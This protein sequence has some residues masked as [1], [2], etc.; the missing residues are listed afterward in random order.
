M[1]RLTRFWRALI[2][3][4]TVALAV[5]GLLVGSAA[6][7]GA[8]APAVST[9]SSFQN[10]DAVVISPDG[11]TAYVADQ[12]AKVGNDYALFVVSTATNTITRTIT[13]PSFD[14]PM[15]VALSPSGSELYVLNISGTV[16]VV[17]TTTD[18]VTAV[19]GTANGEAIYPTPQG[20]VISP[21]GTT[22]YVAHY[23][24]GIVSVLNLTTNSVTRTITVSSPEALALTPSGKD[25]Y[26]SDGFDASSPGVEEIS[27]TTGSVVGSVTGLTPGDGYASLDVSPDGSTLYVVNN[28]GYVDNVPT[29]TNAVASTVSGFSGQPGDSVLSP[30]GSALYVGEG[31]D[32]AVVDTATGTIADE[33]PFGSAAIIGNLPAVSA[34]AV[35][36]SGGS[37]YVAG[38]Q[39]GLGEFGV[40][41]TATATLTGLTPTV[42]LNPVAVAFSPDGK[43]AYVVNGEWLKVP[44]SVT[45]IDTATGIA[46]AVIQLPEYSFPDGIAVSPDGQTIY[47]TDSGTSIPA[48]AGDTVSVIDAAT[49]AVTGSITVG[50]APAGAA[51]SP[52][53][54]T[55]YVANSDDNTVS[56]IDVATETAINT[57]NVGT[58][59][60]SVAVSPDGST[61]YVGTRQGISVIDTASDTVTASISQSEAI[62]FDVVLSPDGQT[63]YA[64]AGE[65]LVIS[66][67]TDT[68]SATNSSVCVANLAIALDGKTVYGS[69]A[70]EVSELSST[71]ALTATITDPS[72]GQLEGLAVS[73]SSGGIYLTD[74]INDSVHV[75]TPAPAGIAPAITSAA[76]ATF[77]VGTKGTFT[78]VTSGSPVPAITESGT[79]PKGVAFTAGANGTATL[80]GTPAAGT[81]KI[82]TLT[83]TAANGVGTVAT[84]HFK[85]TVDQP[86]KIT[87]AAKATFTYHR[88]ASFVIRTTG[89]PVVATITES[90]ALPKG[91][92]FRNN[93][94]GTATIAGTPQQKADK[95]YT[96]KIKASN[97]VSPAMTLTFKLTLKK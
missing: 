82:Y 69:C 7:E 79:L 60:G 15:A 35:S 18:S 73:P 83:I 46:T 30:N 70:S 9:I 37:V 4:L 68:V 24:L 90:G 41:S 53:G 5:S 56:V 96:L 2:G 59:P 40:I 63:L 67:K 76:A 54:T 93:K 13:D 44:A 65:L 78:V 85:L 64:G 25:L 14:E 88:K 87:S 58:D 66:T 89:Y 91:L 42:G 72:F 57:I 51:F 6:A 10:P 95:T 47:V 33:I 20:I 16:S 28:A 22:A 27:T 26:V 48:E 84:Q 71:G 38:T 52:D 75:L 29:A 61:V 21:D 45:V 17:S 97:G 43:Q 1:R 94:N 86:P 23:S 39:Y 81:G 77:K 62:P 11:K 36:P 74:E 80:S 32:V 8:T 50:N 31:T 49:D 55:A 92:T 3:T 19:I 34:L 12:W